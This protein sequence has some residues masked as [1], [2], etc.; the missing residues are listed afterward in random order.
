MYC[1]KC[2]KEMGKGVVEAKEPWT[3]GLK[4]IKVIWWPESE[5]DKTFKHHAKYFENYSKTGY[6]CK[7]C[8]KLYTEFNLGDLY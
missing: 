5:K 4:N 7:N 1:S 3:F 8:Q 2:G 6:Y